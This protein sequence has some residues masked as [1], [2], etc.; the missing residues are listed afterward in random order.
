[1]ASPNRRATG[2]RELRRALERMDDGVGLPLPGRKRDLDVRTS[3]SRL[4]LGRALVA[5]RRFSILDLWTASGDDRGDG[6]D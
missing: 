3:L 1:M 6:R 5:R 4:G 2:R